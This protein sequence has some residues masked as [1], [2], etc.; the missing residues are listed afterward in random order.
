VQANRRVTGVAEVTTLSSHVCSLLRYADDDGY[1]PRGL[2]TTRDIRGCH[3]PRPTAVEPA[4]PM[5]TYLWVDPAGDKQTMA[6]R[7]LNPW[8]S[9]TL[10]AAQLGLEAQNVIAL[11]LIHLAVGG[12]SAQA[13]AKRMVIEKATTFLE[14][15]LATAA[16]L[17]SG[18]GH[19]APRQA[20]GLYRRRVRA[21]RRRLSPSF[22]N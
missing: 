2:R 1:A 15:Q 5:V 3:T 6:R 16:S 14:A 10:D 7:V 8:M 21:N 17:M 19:S 9:L 4:A 20:L 22:W 18:R 11:R 13:E 12:P